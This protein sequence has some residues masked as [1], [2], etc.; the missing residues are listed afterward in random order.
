MLFFWLLHTSIC[1]KLPHSL[2]SHWFTA[3]TCPSACL[4]FHQVLLNFF[5]SSCPFYIVWRQSSTGMCFPVFFSLHCKLYDLIFCLWLAS[6]GFPAIF[7]SSKRVLE[8]FHLVHH[9][10]YLGSAALRLITGLMKTAHLWSF[11][12]A[13][14]STVTDHKIVMACRTN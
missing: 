11:K 1:A 7:I 5:P 3:V 14:V 4:L 8:A 12:D 13:C 6:A 9:G 10:E 2:V